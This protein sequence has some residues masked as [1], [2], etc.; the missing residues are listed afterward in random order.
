MGGPTSRNRF[1]DDG[2]WWWDG[3]SWKPT[4]S[5]DRRWRWDGER[6]V[7]AQPGS[8]P[9]VSPAGPP[10]APPP[11]VQAQSPTPSANPI[12][13]LSQAQIIGIVLAIVLIGGG[14]TAGVVAYQHQSCT[15]GVYST[16]LEITA[17]GPHSGDYC[18]MLLGPNSAGVQAYRIDQPDTNATLMC[19]VTISDGTL[20]T[21]RDKGL[22]RLYG[23][24]VCQKLESG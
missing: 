9:R 18:Q 24:A 2:M 3:A 21:V 14:V 20:V 16:D 22:L 10:P 8:S 23:A 7:S 11:R 4:L 13:G 19:S 17:A 5:P 6:W 15:V 12:G 1:S